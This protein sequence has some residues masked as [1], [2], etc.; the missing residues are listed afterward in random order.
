[1]PL[2]LELQR[3]QLLADRQQFQRDQ[4]KAAEMRALQSPTL[5]PQTPTLLFPPPKFVPSIQQQPPAAVA[6]PAL[7]QPQSPSD[8]TEKASKPASQ[9][10]VP[11]SPQPPESSESKADDDEGSPARKVPEEVL[12]NEQDEQS[13]TEDTHGGTTTVPKGSELSQK[14]E[15][16]EE[17]SLILPAAMP[18]ISAEELAL[19]QQDSPVSGEHSEGKSNGPLVEEDLTTEVTG[20]MTPPGRDAFVA[21][22]CDEQ[23]QMEVDEG[24]KAFSQ[25]ETA[26]NTAE[27]Q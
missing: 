26:T 12:N 4:L 14:D 15:A 5:Q 11:A 1:M 19:V 17:P 2:Q 10:P 7:E 23:Q 3:Q 27:E 6:K 13:G 24:G 21:E 16:I 18:T 8:V 25:S 20:S 9:S 22:C